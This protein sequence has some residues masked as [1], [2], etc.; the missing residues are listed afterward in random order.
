VSYGQAL[1][2]HGGVARQSALRSERGE[3]DDAHG[4]IKETSVLEGESRDLSGYCWFIQ[5]GSL[6]MCPG[7]NFRVLMDAVLARFGMPDE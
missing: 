2:G 4:E 1:P 6:E 7:T 5:L 3:R